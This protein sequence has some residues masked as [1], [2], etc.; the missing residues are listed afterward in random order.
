MRVLRIVESDRP[1]QGFIPVLKQAWKKGR[2]GRVR[3]IVQATQKY[4]VQEL[5]KTTIP[6]V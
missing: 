6:K 1:I 3:R 2:K 4:V 5:V